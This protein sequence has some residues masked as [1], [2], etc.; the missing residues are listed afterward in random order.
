MHGEAIGLRK[1]AGDEVDTGFHQGT[2]EVDVSREPVELGDHQRGVV[3]ATE[4]EGLRNFGTVIALPALHLDDLLDE[5]PMTTIQV[6][7]DNL[8]LRLQTQA[9]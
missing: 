6:L 7:V 3:E 5:P 2:Y 1:V 8:A 9:T 4:P